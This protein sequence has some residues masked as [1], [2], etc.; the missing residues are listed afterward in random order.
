M[1]KVLHFVS[2][3]SIGSGVMSVIMNYYRHMDRSRIQFDFLCF[4]PCKDSY[5]AEINE[6]GGRVFFI[7]K[8]G[9]SLKSIWHI[10]RFFCEHQNEYGYFHNHEV[11]L[12]FFLKP[13]VMYCE[14]PT[15]IVHSHAT[16]YSDRRVAAIRNQ[17]LCF[18]ISFM[19]CEKF[20]CSKAA[21]AFL[22]GKKTIQNCAVHIVHNAIEVEKFMFNNK[23]REQ[24]RRQ[25]DIEDCFVLGHVGRFV[26]Q[27]NHIFLLNVFARISETMP[28]VKLLLVGDGPLKNEVQEYCQKLGIEKNVLF[29]GQRKD[30]EKVYSAMDVFVLPSIF[31][32]V[33]ISLIEA[34]ANGLM[35]VASDEVPQE[36]KIMNYVKFLP[37]IPEY[38]ETE[39]KRLMRDCQRTEQENIRDQFYEMHYEIEAESQWLQK[40]YEN[41]NINVCL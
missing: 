15:F 31:E 23:W 9:S 22:F 24:L 8:P 30:I 17:M 25:F 18:P 10:Y 5:E 28:K 34:Q 12:S 16:K 29:V 35:C 32:G 7:P 26:P 41:T 39:L 20:A 36:A 6:L 38:W 21:G 1:I 14:I 27:K 40:Y 11:Y 19:K 3:P 13:L 2:T 33:G 37:L 4:I